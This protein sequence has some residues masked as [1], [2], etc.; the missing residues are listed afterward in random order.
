MEMKQPDVEVCSAC[1]LWSECVFSF[2]R[3]IPEILDT[4]RSSS[5][6][7]QV[8][9]P[10]NPGVCQFPSVSPW[11]GELLVQTLWWEA[12]RHQMWGDQC[13][14]PVRKRK[15]GGDRDSVRFLEV[16]LPRS[17]C[18]CAESN[19][20]VRWEESHRPTLV[21]DKNYFHQQISTKPDGGTGPWKSPW[22]FGG[23]CRNHFI[24][25]NNA[26][27]HGSW[28]KSLGHNSFLFSFQEVDVKNLHQSFSPTN[29]HVSL[30]TESLTEFFWLFSSTSSII[31]TKV[32]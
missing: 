14:A 9:L 12:N 26:I 13:E 10:G 31:C 11:S 4:R 27:I 30:D 5:N 25:D 6:T 21:S 1:S 8:R 20:S 28:C 16:H 17:E 3:L 18:W 32:C 23:G 15:Q 22:N 24:N 29:H 19:Q 7:W 2:Q